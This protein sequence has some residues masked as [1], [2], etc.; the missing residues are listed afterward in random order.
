MANIQEIARLA[1][2]STA[3]VSRVLNQ[4]PYVNETK[5]KKFL[6]SLKILTM[7]LIPM[8]NHSKKG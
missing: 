7:Y 3:T 1:G 5:R 2:V 4:H 6:R 8:R